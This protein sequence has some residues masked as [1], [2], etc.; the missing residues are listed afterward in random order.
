MKIWKRLLTLMMAVLM[1]VTGISTVHADDIDDFSDG[2]EVVPYT[3]TRILN[4]MEDHTAGYVIDENTDIDYN[5]IMTREVSAQ[6]KKNIESLLNFEPISTQEVTSL[7]GKTAAY[8]EAGGLDHTAQSVAGM[9]ESSALYQQAQAL[10]VEDTRTDLFDVIDT[11]NNATGYI[12]VINKDAVCFFIADESDHGISGALVTI[13]YKNASGKTIIDSQYTTPEPTPGVVAFDGLTDVDYLTL[14]INAAGYHG[15]TI[16]DLRVNCGD[17]M[18]FHLKKSVTNDLYVRCIDLEGKDLQNED[19]ELFLVESGS[20][21]IPLRVILTATDSRKIP[22]TVKIVETGSGNTVAVMSNPVS[23]SDKEGRSYMYTLNEDWVKKDYLLHDGDHL[24]LQFDTEQ[25]NIGLLSIHNAL[26]TP[27]AE[28]GELPVAGGDVDVPLTDVI[29]GTGIA[30]LTVSWLKVPVTIGIFPEG[31]FIIV[32]TF[33]IDSMSESYSSLFK[34]SWKPKT[35][36]EGE[37]VLEP[38]KQSFWQKADRFK[39]GQGSLDTKKKWNFKTD[40]SISFSVSFSLFCSGKYNEKTGNFDGSFG[41]LFNINLTG[42]ITQYFLLTAPVFIPFYAGF[43]ISGVFKNSLT[44]N[45]LWNKIG[46]GISAVFSA[47]H[48]MVRRHDLLAGLDLFGGAGLRGACSLEAGGGASMDFGWVVGTLE[49]PEECRFLIDAFTHVY[50]R[51]NILFFTIKIIDNY[52][53]PWRLYDT[54][55]DKLTSFEAPAQ[56]VEIISHDLAATEEKATL[57]LQGDGET[58][59]VYKMNT[60]LLGDVSLGDGQLLQTLSVDTYGDSQP[61]MISTVDDTVLFRLAIVDGRSRVVYQRLDKQTGQFENEFHVVHIFDG[62]DVAEYHVVADQNRHNVAYIA[63]V[64]ADSRVEDLDER[65]LT[66]MVTVTTVDLTN[67]RVVMSEERSPHSDFGQ[68]YYFYPRIAADNGTVAVAYRKASSYQNRYRSSV[69]CM[70]RYDTLEELEMGTGRFFTNGVIRQGEPS[71]FIIDE[72]HTTNKKLVIQG[73]RANGYVNRAHPRMRFELD[74]SGMTFGDNE[75]IVSNWGFANGTNYCVIGGQLY[76]LEKYAAAIDEYGYA[77]RLTKIEGA[78]KFLNTE[79]TYQFVLND[80]ASA[81]YIVSACASY[82]V[83]M[84]TGDNE[85]AGSRISIY[86]LESH[87]NEET[88]AEEAL[89]HGPLELFAKDQDINRFTAAFSPAVERTGG[90]SM[91][92]ATAPEAKLQDNG[93]IAYSG[94]IYYWRHTVTNGMQAIAVDISDFI[95]KTDQEYVPVFI[96]YRNVGYAIEGPVAFNFTDNEGRVL[97]EVEYRNGKYQDVG[98]Q[99]VHYPAKV[100]PGDSWQCE[101]LVRPDSAWQANK[102]YEINVEVTD[103]FAGDT[104]NV[105]STPLNAQSMTL[106]GSQIVLEGN[107]YALLNVSNLGVDA[108]RINK[109]A[110]ETMYDDFDK[111]NHIGYIDLSR[112]TADADQDGYNIRYDVQPYWDRA[113]EEGIHALKFYLL[114]EN[115]EILT[116]EPVMIYPRADEQVSYKITSGAGQTWTRG[117]DEGCKITV[118]RSSDDSNC[119]SYFDALIIDGVEWSRPEEYDAEKGSTILTLKPEALGALETG[120]H[121][122]QIRFTDG[123]VA[124]TLKVKAKQSEHED[125]PFTG[126]SSFMAGWYLAV[127]LALLGALKARRYLLHH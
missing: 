9:L 45:F 39:D 19:T 2:G 31:G 29:G 20:S 62:R 109:I 67:D 113:E 38:L 68:Y 105:V 59:D 86:T 37:S 60:S 18:P 120:K 107:H 124:T 34:N 112:V 65:A 13:T 24:Q 35:R 52:W 63:A 16:L 50:A 53:G 3:L 30:G 42:G 95:V 77:M 61:Q 36:A 73:Y 111:E 27:G 1:T 100:Y 115:G 15:K 126:D 85:I 4:D 127:A 48:T 80:D 91:V 70:V 110:V 7:L 32:A 41:G 25:E 102:T 75:D 96:T 93:K 88:G 6:L 56:Q 71:F 76:Y 117:S 14:D 40:K 5:P 72:T 101:V 108:A 51:A 125:S 79:G 47:P 8:V 90:L 58:L 28:D 46:D 55:P 106:S 83:D 89:L 43:E 123:S 121:E 98:T 84:E 74:I 12:Y 54:D 57:Q 104:N 118:S 66:S 33:D 22:D 103:E 122:V 87:I 26:M 17:I 44:F 92:F 94:D 49:D 69:A 21:A 10:G 81:L 23:Y 119:I 99:V 116:G 82:D 78:D 114:D 64:T 97:H 11:Q